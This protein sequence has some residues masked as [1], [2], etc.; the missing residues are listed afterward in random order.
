[1]KKLAQEAQLDLGMSWVF[2]H[3]TYSIVQMV[4]MQMQNLS[5]FSLIYVYLWWWPM[6][7]TVLSFFWPKHL[8]IYLNMSPQVSLRS[9][10]PRFFTRR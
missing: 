4:N 5:V 9:R 1:M 3:G 6:K 8:A 10:G 7:E 2:V